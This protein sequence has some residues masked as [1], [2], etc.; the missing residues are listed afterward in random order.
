MRIEPLS[1]GRW[2]VF[3]MIAQPGKEL[4]FESFEDIEAW[5]MDGA[6]KLER[7]HNDPKNAMLTNRLIIQ[8]F[9]DDTPKNRVIATSLNGIV[10]DQETVVNIL[11]QFTGAVQHESNKS[12]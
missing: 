6:K 4:I 12:G 8:F 3:A 9:L 7:I 5:I 2:R 11:T 1:D 10:T